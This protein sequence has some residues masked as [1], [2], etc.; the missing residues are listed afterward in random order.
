[1]NGLARALKGQGKVEEAIAVWKEM[2]KL[3]PGVT[4]ATTG[5]AWTYLEQGK[6]DEAVKYFEQLAKAAPDDASAKEGLERAR[7][8][9]AQ[10]SGERG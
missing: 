1:M 5:L 10:A 3:V 7:K 8:G 9:L 2:E 4:A 6:Y